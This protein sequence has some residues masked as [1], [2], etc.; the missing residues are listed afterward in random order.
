MSF[1]QR[2]STRSAV[3]MVVGVCALLVLYVTGSGSGGRRA[4]SEAAAVAGEAGHCH[5]IRDFGGSLTKA[6]RAIGSTETTLHI[7]APA[8]VGGDTT[9]PATLGLVFRKGGRIKFGDSKVQINGPIEAGPYRIFEGTGR[10]TIADNAVAELH[11]EWWGG[12]ADGATDNTPAFAAAIAAMPDP[13]IRLLQGTYLGVI[14]ASDKTVVLE[15]SGKKTTT[16]RNNAPAT[17]TIWLNKSPYGTRIGDVTIDM[18][19]ARKTGILLSN[20]NYADMQRVYIIGQADGNYALHVANCTLSSFND[21]VF[22]DDNGGHLLVERSFY[23]N[24][25][26]ISSGRSRTLAAVKITDTSSLH[27]YGLYVEH[28]QNGS[29]VLERAQN[30]NFYGIGIELAD[31]VPAKTG[32]IRVNSCQA[33]NFYGGRVN[34]YAHQGRPVFDLSRTQGCTVDGWYLRRS[35]GDK[36]AFVTLGPGLDNI[37]ISNI[38]FASNVAAIGVQSEKGRGSRAGNVVLENLT[39]G[40]RGLTHAVN[41]TDLAARNVEGKIESP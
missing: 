34:Q 33:I 10:V 40:G 36:S 3:L 12:A 35:S 31:D 22:G 27:F 11:V 8:V 15:G 38:E 20:C 25:R 16:L 30:V 7:D 13:K 39:A 21:V 18:N 26:N 9:A 29:I 28:G 19:G 32:F 5:S 41:A 6:L 2:Y 17:N 24:F 1:K 23:S 37:R 4:S 14:S